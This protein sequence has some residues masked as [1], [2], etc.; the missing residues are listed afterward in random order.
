MSD[1]Q[2][3]SKVL[4]Q[5]GI[6][7]GSTDA[8]FGVLRY[9]KGEPSEVVDGNRSRWMAALGLDGYPVVVSEQVHGNRVIVIDVAPTIGG[10][11]QRGAA[12]ALITA[13]P[14]V[15]LAIKTADCVPVL[16]ADPVKQVVAVVHSGWKGTALNIVGHTIARMGSRFGCEP[17]DIIAAVGPSICVNHYDVSQAND[18][19]VDRFIQQFG[20]DASIVVRKDGR[21][22]LDLVAACKQQC[23]T[24]GV[25]EASI[26][27]SGVCTLEESRW[28][29]YRRD[30]ER[31]H[32]D[33]WSYIAIP[34]K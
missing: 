25:R 20:D 29:S 33:V 2:W 18:G 30:A 14:G 6:L 32:G 23:L 5:R 8:S 13:L 15:V 21:V 16:L 26:D 3:T 12:D 7:H 4:T 27:M 28:P 22:A 11:D 34:K 10:F 1:H 24:A 19:R 31:L 17:Q 9:E